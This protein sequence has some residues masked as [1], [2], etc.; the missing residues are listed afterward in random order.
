[1][2]QVLLDAGASKSVKNDDG[3]TPYDLIC[4]DEYRT[5]Y[6]SERSELESLLSL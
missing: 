5:C 4:V 2:V 3:R 1:M 6:D